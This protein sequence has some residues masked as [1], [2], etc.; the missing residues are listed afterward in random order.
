MEEVV[1]LS[2]GTRVENETWQSRFGR[3]AGDS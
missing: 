2:V 1:E 3:I